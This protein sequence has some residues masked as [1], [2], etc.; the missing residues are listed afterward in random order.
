MFA[1]PS[2]CALEDSELLRMVTLSASR[3]QSRDGGWIVSMI[4]ASAAG[5]SLPRENAQSCRFRPQ[6]RQ[7]R[8]IRGIRRSDAPFLPQ[9]DT[10]FFSSASALRG[11]ASALDV[12]L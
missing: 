5:H 8:V 11:P 2:R 1:C 9:L 10:A 12:R 6:H 7:L 4:G 3:E